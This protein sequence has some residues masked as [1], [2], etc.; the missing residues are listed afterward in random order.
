MRSSLSEAEA[1][2]IRWSRV[3]R[4]ASVGPDGV[5]HVVPVSP[6]LDGDVVV[7]ATEPTAKLGFLRADPR[8]AI[9]WD[10]Y[11]DDWDLLRQVQ[12]RGRAEIVTQGPVWERG[13]SL[14]DEKFPQYALTFPITPGHTVIVRVRAER[15]TSD[16]F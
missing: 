10:V 16:G 3:A 12:I 4:F 8:C 2:F 1:S 13:K 15:V 9:V 14:L 6:A 5:P 7:F 11:Q